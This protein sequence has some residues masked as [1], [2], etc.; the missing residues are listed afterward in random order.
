MCAVSL[1]IDHLAVYIL[2]SPFALIAYLFVGIGLMDWSR[3]RE[4]RLQDL[5]VISLT[6][7][8]VGPIPM[9]E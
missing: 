2:F 8:D 1:P 7:K 3:M 4:V 5:L 6:R 9:M